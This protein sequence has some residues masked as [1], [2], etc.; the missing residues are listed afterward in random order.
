MSKGCVLVDKTLIFLQKKP[1][2]FS[3]SLVFAML[4]WPAWL[5]SQEHEPK[6][7][8]MIDIHADTQVPA[9][10]AEA[11]EK[12]ILREIMAY[13]HVQVVG[14]PKVHSPVFED[15]PLLEKIRLYGRNG[16][17]VVFFG[18]LST[19]RFY[20]Q[21]YECWTPARVENDSFGLDADMS[22]I[23]LKQKILRASTVFTKREALLEDKLHLAVRGEDRA[24]A[25]PRAESEKDAVALTRGLG[26]AAFGF[27]IF[28]FVPIGLY[29]GMGRGRQTQRGRARF[30]RWLAPLIILF[31]VLG[32]HLSTNWLVHVWKYMDPTGHSGDA[33][34]SF[35]AKISG[36]EWLIAVFGGMLWGWFA[37]AALRTAF[38]PIGGLD[39]IGHRQVLSMLRAW[40]MVC[41]QRMALLGLFFVP[42]ACLV[43]WTVVSYPQYQRFT[44][45]VVAPLLGII[46]RGWWLAVVECCAVY[47]DRRLVEGP[48]STQNPWHRDV[49]KYF[50]GYLNR[51]GWLIEEKLL[52]RLLFLPGNAPGVICYGGGITH[53]RIIIPAKL[54][55]IAI[56]DPEEVAPESSFVRWSSWQ[57][58][59]LLAHNPFN[60]P[61]T[62]SPAVARIIELFSKLLGLWLRSS[63]LRSARSKRPG[64][65]RSTRRKN[66]GQAATSL[67]YTLPFPPEE[68]VPLIA[69]STEDFEIVRELLAEHYAW[70]EP[71]P[72]D[73]YD[74][75]DPTD[76]DFL[77]G[78]L[79]REIGRI[80]REE[81][82]FTTLVLA[83]EQKFSKNL[84]WFD[85]LYSGA[86]SFCQRFLS[87]AMAV[88]ADGYTSLNFA[89][90][91]LIQYLYYL[92]WRDEKLLTERAD[93]LSLQR[94]SKEIFK[95]VAD[96]KPDRMDLQ[97]RRATIRNRLVWLSQFS[98]IGLAEAKNRSM[99]MI[100]T[101]VLSLA[102][103]VG[104][105]LLIKNAV[106]YHPTYIERMS[107][108]IRNTD[109]FPRDTARNEKGNTEH[110]QRE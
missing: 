41:L 88:L 31:C 25:A 43:F 99:R 14:R 47:L 62:R 101:V 66:L 63:A 19:D 52:E 42:I 9:W 93:G 37:M 51:T 18:R 17:D 28:L 61:P 7:A 103:L 76:K 81:S 55:H 27:A 67:G 96:S 53:P 106:D 36:G 70:F 107:R 24:I 40:L 5:Y 102:A 69:D 4:L 60:A 58:G 82:L 92:T 20:Y 6:I 74:D 109:V 90:H 34:A 89:H 68:L 45:I 15:M 1:G 78:A 83:I 32:L 10:M 21:I 75:T 94:V 30:V 46:F 35:W 48:A 97:P 54:L 2:L 87:R 39:R 72:A 57:K 100:V 23:R 59:M 49:K 85:K 64:R 16:I 95:M 56:G 110:D 8:V 71:D 98:L 12:N 86:F 91:H 80:Q 104:V 73:E 105:G 79:V 108:Q 44:V 77:F 29:L 65:K 13:Q 3:S 22:I 50:Q 33:V 38:P 84:P 26:F 11:M